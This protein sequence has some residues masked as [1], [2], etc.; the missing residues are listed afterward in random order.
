MISS[1]CFKYRKM[2]SRFWEVVGSVTE[3]LTGIPDLGIGRWDRNLTSSRIVETDP[4]DAGDEQPKLE[5]ER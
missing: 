5:A 2:I 3:P 1:G 4:R